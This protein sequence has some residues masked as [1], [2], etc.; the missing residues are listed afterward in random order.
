VRVLEDGAIR[1]AGPHT[2]TWDGRDATGRRVAPGIYFYVLN[3]AGEIARE[4]TILLR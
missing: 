2:A 1:D 3:A 4:R